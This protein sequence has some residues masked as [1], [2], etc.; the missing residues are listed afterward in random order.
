M[1]LISVNKIIV[2]SNS[3]ASTIAEAALPV[4]DITD[5]LILNYKWK[6]FGLPFLQVVSVRKWDTEL[7]F[8]N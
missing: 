6:E 8:E 4:V 3:N 5:N 1:N 7:R 2:N